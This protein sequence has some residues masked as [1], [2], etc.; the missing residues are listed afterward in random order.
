MMRFIDLGKQIGCDEEDWPREFAFFNTV[1]SRFLE[2]KGS[3]TW[4]SWAL[5][6]IDFNEDLELKNR[7]KRL[8]PE[9]V[10]QKK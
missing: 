5:F 9:W 6:E 3:Q 10:F 4:S 2:F 8:C 7:L 1:P